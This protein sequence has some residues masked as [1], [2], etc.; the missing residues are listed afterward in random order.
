MAGVTACGA[1]DQAHAST[2][3][4]SNRLLDAVGA[5]RAKPALNTEFTLTRNAPGDP[6][7]DRFAVRCVLR[8]YFVLIVVAAVPAWR[9]RHFKWLRLTNT[10]LWA[11]RV[12]GA[13][14][15]VCRW[16]PW[17]GLAMRMFHAWS[18][19]SPAGCG[20]PI[21]SATRSCNSSA[22]CLTGAVPCTS[23]LHRRRTA[24]AMISVAQNVGGK[25]LH[26]LRDAAG[27]HRCHHVGHHLCVRVRHRSW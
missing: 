1:S 4:V 10:G 13:G 24:K 6:H 7:V 18:T 12:V 27:P 15:V 25:R 26:F 23:Q 17:W 20:R 11:L 3:I 14:A 5:K 22:A 21:K 16:E 8:N 9:L 19:P 2:A